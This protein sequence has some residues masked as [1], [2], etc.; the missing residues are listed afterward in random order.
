MCVQGGRKNGRSGARL[1]WVAVLVACRPAAPPEWLEAGRLG[2]VELFRPAGEPSGLVVL[3]SD[4]DGWSARW[5]AAARSLQGRGAAVVGVDLPAYLAGLRASDDGCHYVVAEIEELSKRVQRELA[6]ERYLSPIVAGAGEGALFAYAALAQA[7]AA[8]LAGAVSA[9]PAPALAT[10]VPFCPGAPS[11]P[12]GGGG[13][14]YGPRSPLPGFWRVDS[15]EPLASDLAALAIRGAPG[16]A[17]DA[18]ARVADLV[19]A[20][21]DAEG[22]AS[23]LRD[24]PLTEI[25]VAEPGAWMAV[26]YSG[27]GG[28]RDIDK[29]IGEALARD[30][31]P[32][33]GVDSLRYFWRRKGPAQVASDLA[34]ILRYYGEAWGTRKAVLVGYSFGAGILPFAVNRLPEAERVQVLQVSLLGLASRAPFEFHVSGWLGSGSREDPLVMPELERLPPSLLQCFY[35]AEEE[36]TVCRAPELA[37]AEVIGTLGGHHFDGDYTALARRIAEGAARRL[38]AP[39]P[40]RTPPP[41]ARRGGA[42]SR[43]APGASGCRSRDGR[44]RGRRGGRLPRA[45]SCSRP[46]RSSPRS[47]RSPDCRDHGDPPVGCGSS[48]D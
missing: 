25:P 7:P 30:G 37:G 3:L 31:A 29:Q 48:S 9:D 36:D 16:E 2:R 17:A 32:V 26:I 10:K 23:P 24:L 18:A 44:G 33:V 13:F 4:S 1:A 41:A 11:A 22:E 20:A 27:D 28:W 15:R 45:R 34:E 8:T 12:A 14:A 47:G 39:T 6:S 43:A 5:E 46:W 40:A 35:G 21:L 19:A 42:G 38:A